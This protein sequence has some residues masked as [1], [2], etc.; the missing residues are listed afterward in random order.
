MAYVLVIDKNNLSYWAFNNI[1]KKVYLEKSVNA[2]YWVQAQEKKKAA[3]TLTIQM[4]CSCIAGGF[5]FPTWGTPGRNK[6]GYGYGYRT[7]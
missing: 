1:F 6:V 7:C 2:A 4:L 3:K 5:P